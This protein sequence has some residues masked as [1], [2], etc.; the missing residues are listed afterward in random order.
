MTITSVSRIT[1]ERRLPTPPEDGQP[2]S[3]P[4]V[5]PAPDFPFRGW[6]PPQPEGYR[7]S[8]ANP[9]ENAI[10]IDNGAST[11]KAGFS[12]DKTPRL[13]VPPLVAKYKDRKY[14]K[15]CMFVGHDAYADATT[16]GQIRTAFEQNTS[17][18]TNWDIMENIY[19]YIFLKLGVDNEGSVG[20]PLVVT[21]PVANLGHSRRMMNEMLFECY[22]VPSVTYGIDSLFSYR[23]NKGTSGLIVSSSHTS[24]HIIPVLDRKPQMQSCAR[25]NWGGSQAQEFLFKLIRLKYPNF[26]GKMTTEQTER[27]IKQYCYLSNDYS[28]EL[29]TYLDWSGLEEERDIII[30]YP[31]TEQVVVEKSAEELARIAERKKES[32]RRLQEQAAKMRLEKLVR[33][34]QELEYYQQ[35]HESYVNAPTKKEQR[36]ILDGEE[37][38]DE[39]A[40]ERIVRDLDR[41]IKKSRNKDLGAPEEEEKLEEQLNKFPLLEVPDDQLD[42]DGL[43]EKRH[44]RLMKSGVE[45]RIRAKAEKERERARV[46][47]AER[48]DVEMR[49]NQ[50]DE[51]LSGRREQRDTLLSRIKEQARLKADSGNRKGI[52]S[53][54]R[55]KTLANLASDGPK[56]KRRGGGEYDDDFGANDED[57]GVYRAVATEPASDDEEPEEDPMV[58]L[59]AV[60]SELLQYDP[61]FSEKDTVE[62]QNDWTKSTLHAFLRGARPADPESQREANQIHLN[63]ERIRVPEVVFQPG[64]AGVDQAGLVEI[65]E[66]IVT[67]RFSDFAQQQALL[68]DVFLTGGNTMFTNFEERLKRELVASVPDRLT[69]NVRK[70]RDPVLDAWR[71]AASWWSSGARPEREAATITQAEYMEKGSDYIKAQLPTI[72]GGDGPYQQKSKRRK[73]QVRKVAR[74]LF[75]QIMHR[76]LRSACKALPMLQCFEQANGICLSLFRR[77]TVGNDLGFLRSVADLRIW[78]IR[79]PFSALALM[80]RTSLLIMTPGLQDWN[81]GTIFTS[82]LLGLFE[83]TAG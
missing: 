65:I 71:G 11:I 12:F 56:R 62:A 72:I 82:L 68:K 24:T 27:Y 30:Q 26:T 58:A 54:M 13:F 23:Y 42:E 73:S 17:I 53:Q 40:L 32:G 41:S 39:A 1:T 15:Y 2:D 21:E 9:S 43:K 31:F 14:N 20:R 74:N 7:Q 59:R 29:S 78:D 81:G 79:C 75:S 57:W 25:L 19:D 67:G 46:A 16:R 4:R 28:A 80:L 48:R 66:G 6:Q 3:Q 22:G 50:F 76:I 51:W 77:F 34:E 69:V 10:V 18:P 49:E 63:V 61:D 5:H 64:I 60:E 8:A 47:E 70:A 33:K 45:A 35:L 83:K 44:Q 52:A 55:M 36:R 38:K 37:L